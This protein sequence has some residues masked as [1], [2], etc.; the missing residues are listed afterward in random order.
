MEQDAY[1]ALLQ[2][3]ER[4]N[5]SKSRWST[6]AAI[7]ADGAMV[8][9]LRRGAWPR[10]VR[11]QRRKIETAIDEL[12]RMLGRHPAPREIASRLGWT[13]VKYA[14]V[15]T[16]IATIEATVKEQPESTHD[17]PRWC[18]PLAWGAHEIERD[19]TAARL[20]RMIRTLPD[21]ERWI[22]ERYYYGEVSMLE[23][24][25]ELGVNESRI[26]QLHARALRMLGPMAN[27]LR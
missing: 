8:D 14:R 4:F 6:F 19:D 25:Y 7:R 10:S 20:R 2:A 27:G 21:R 17:V 9:G 24:G 13:E 1:V 5:P 23:I 3:S 12:V 15:R 22:V 11:S 16:R 18:R 26:S